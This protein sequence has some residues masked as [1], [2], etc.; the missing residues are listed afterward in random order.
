MSPI[1]DLDVLEKKNILPIPDSNPEP[2]SLSP[3]HYTD[4][5]VPSA[6]LSLEIS[7]A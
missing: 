7:Q 1:G 5:T 6:K 3:S 4:Y 2:S